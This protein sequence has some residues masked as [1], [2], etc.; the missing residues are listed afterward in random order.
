MRWLKGGDIA[1][2]YT[3]VTTR[4]NAG[5]VHIAKIQL[6]MWNCCVTLIETTNRLIKDV[7]ETLI[8]RIKSCSLFKGIVLMDDMKHHTLKVAGVY[9]FLTTCSDNKV[10]KLDG[11]LVCCLCLECS[12]ISCINILCTSQNKI[13][14][15]SFQAS[16]MLDQGVHFFLLLSKSSIL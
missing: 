8:S 12:N 16:F 4:Q 3:K 6:S 7:V 15:H 5:Y 10:P 11:G 1:I 13:Q 2:S 9:L 14:V